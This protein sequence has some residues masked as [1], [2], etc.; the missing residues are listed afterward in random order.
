MALA[1]MAAAVAAGEPLSALGDEV[2]TATHGRRAEEAYVA[3]RLRRG[4]W[5][6]ESH[7]ATYGKAFKMRK[8]AYWGGSRKLVNLANERAAAAPSTLDVYEFGVYT[9]RG[10]PCPPRPLPIVRG[11]SLSPAGCDDARHGP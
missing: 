6:S 11:S 5:L 4:K 8:V 10:R 2:A 3:P 1:A 9:V 7:D